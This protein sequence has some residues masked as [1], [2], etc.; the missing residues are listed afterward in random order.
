MIA[1]DGVYFWGK[2]Q[3]KKR[4]FSVSQRPQAGASGRSN[5]GASSETLTE[6]F[7]LPQRMLLPAATKVVSVAAGAENLLLLTA[8]GSVLAMGSNRLGQLGIGH[9]DSVAVPM[10]VVGFERGDSIVAVVCGQYHCAA[11]ASSGRVYT[12]GWGLHGQLAVSDRIRLEDALV[13]TLVN[14]IRYAQLEPTVDVWG[15]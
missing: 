5:E 4:L 6:Q 9:R 7:S 1:Q 12:W 13:P 10:P 14:S 3:T 11:V 8:D 15:V 2:F